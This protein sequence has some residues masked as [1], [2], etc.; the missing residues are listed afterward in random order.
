MARVMGRYLN[1][2]FKQPV[3]VENRPGASTML[4][5]GYVARAD[6]DGYVLM[7][8]SMSYAT[9]A[10]IYSNLT[11]DPINDLVGVTMVSKGPGCWS[12]RHCCRCNRS[13]ISSTTPRRTRARL[14]TPP[15]GNGTVNHLW[16]EQFKSVT[17]TDIVQIPYKGANPAILDVISGRSQI[18]L[19]SLPS[20]WGKVKAGQLRAI[21]ITSPKRSALV[22]ELRLLRKPPA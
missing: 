22:P 16:M 10:A 3:V 11:F 8:T 2:E 17:K 18:F 13:R 6:A 21:A 20:V 4:G 5:A 19:G 7:L 1:E 9:S 14:I 15:R 12:S